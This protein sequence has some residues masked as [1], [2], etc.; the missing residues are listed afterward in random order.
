MATSNIR[1]TGLRTVVTQSSAPWSSESD[2][3]LAECSSQTSQCY[4]SAVSQISRVW[5]CQA[6]PVNGHGRAQLIPRL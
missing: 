1:S 4:T 6:T 5:T 2:C 3:R